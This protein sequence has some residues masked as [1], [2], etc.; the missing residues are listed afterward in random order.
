MPPDIRSQI[1]GT[2]WE[3]GPQFAGIFPAI[4][5]FFSEG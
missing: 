3:A 4:S 5:A 1:I 2:V